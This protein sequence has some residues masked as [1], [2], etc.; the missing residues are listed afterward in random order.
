VENE[1]VGVGENGRLGIGRVAAGQPLILA[2][3]A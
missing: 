3:G 1:E 2:P